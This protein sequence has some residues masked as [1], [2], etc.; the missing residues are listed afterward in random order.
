[1]CIKIKL[2]GTESKKERSERGVGGGRAA[3]RDGHGR[4]SEGREGNGGLRGRWGVGGEVDRL[5]LR[6]LGLG[7]A[8]HVIFVGL[9]FFWQ[10]QLTIDVDDGR[11]SFNS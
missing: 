1:M 5:K 2:Y 6:A 8:P 3:S 10:R 11:M 7:S 9:A 4:W